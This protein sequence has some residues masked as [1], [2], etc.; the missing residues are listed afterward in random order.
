MIEKAITLVGM[1]GV[2]KTH[3]SWALEKQ[4]WHHYNV[5]YLIG[6]KYLKDELKDKVGAA[7]KL[8]DLTPLSKYIGQVGN[9]AKGALPLEEFRRRQKC[10][11][12]AEQQA[13]Y[14]MREA[15]Q[16]YGHKVVNDSTGSLCEVGDEELYAQLGED[17]L[18]VYLH[19][20]KRR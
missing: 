7:V 6:T 15:V 14:D 18:F 16:K 1:S 20:K 19:Q 5:D 17:S 3:W 8:D 2:G 10:Y 4:G 12:D 13:L 11:I 9:P